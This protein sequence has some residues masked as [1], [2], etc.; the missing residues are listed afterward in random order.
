MNTVKAFETALATI[1]TK[2][3]NAVKAAINAIPFTVTEADK[4]TVEAARALYDAYV[5]EYTDYDI[6]R[7]TATP[8]GYVADDF[9]I[10]TLVRAEASLGLNDYS[11]ERE[12]AAKAAAIADIEGLKIKAN[13]TAAKGSITVK[14]TVSEEVEG[15]KYQVYKS[16]KAQKGYTKA[17][18][19]TK[20]SFKNTKNLKAGTRYYYKVRAIGVVDGVTYYSDW[21]NKANRIAK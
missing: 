21:S 4:A 11:A 15:V 9:E 5:A 20:T 8:D 19:T 13:S 3:A 18:T 17:I 16:T 14:W 2:E 7:G 6:A 1:K 10:A 12:A